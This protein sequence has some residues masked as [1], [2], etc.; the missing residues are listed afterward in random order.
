M[1]DEPIWEERLRRLRRI[2]FRLEVCHFLHELG[3]APALTRS[4]I[5][6]CQATR[7]SGDLRQRNNSSSRGS[8][9]V[10]TIVHSVE[11]SRINGLQCQVLPGARE[12]HRHGR[13]QALHMSSTQ[14]V[15][16]IIF[17]LSSRTGGYPLLALTQGTLSFNISCSIG[18]TRLYSCRV[19][20]RVALPGQYRFELEGPLTMWMNHLH[21]AAISEHTALLRLRRRPS[22]VRVKHASSPCKEVIAP[23][24]GE[25]LG[26]MCERGG[27]GGASRCHRRSKARLL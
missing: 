20:R 10:P 2:S 25:V 13:D 16:K 9:R 24:R 18:Q 21:P 22:A 15:P 1:F 23:R 4:E 19:E 12:Y 7:F 26:G 11:K 8:P 5:D 6:S 14:R 17:S 3:E 27:G